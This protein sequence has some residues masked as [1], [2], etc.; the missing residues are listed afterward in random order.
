MEPNSSKKHKSYSSL[1]ATFVVSGVT[2][3]V[4]CTLVWFIHYKQLIPFVYVLVTLALPTLI[5]SLVSYRTQRQNRAA[6]VHTSSLLSKISEQG[7]FSLR[8]EPDA[9]PTAPELVQSLNHLIER[10]ESIVNE[11]KEKQ[12]QLQETLEKQK[13]AEKELKDTHKQLLETSRMAGMAEVTTGMLHNVGNTLT[14]V[15]VSATI[16]GDK[17]RQSDTKHLIKLNKLIQQHS[18]NLADFFQNNP[19]GEKIPGF[20]SNLTEAIEKEHDLYQNEITSLCKHVEHIRD[21]IS[22][23]QNYSKVIGHKEITSPIELM[24]KALF[25]NESSILRHE[26]TINKAY[27]FKDRISLESHK[28]LQILVN[29]V[30]NA[31]Q[32]TKNNNRHN[33]EIVA[34]IHAHDSERIDFQIRDNGT[35]I[36]KEN[37]NRIFQHGFTTK[38]EGHGF[39][40]HNS[41]L[42]A[43]ELGGSLKVYSDGPNQGASFILQ[44]P[45]IRSKNTPHHLS[46]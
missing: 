29:L 40:L 11:T 36:S 20:L 17:L 18:D 13:V 31:I 45:A 6:L 46:L 19:K 41:A 43:K 1:A 14:S 39:G 9:A 3:V 33:R 5:V 24:D 38:T 42:F 4:M 15:N 34:Y 32:A 22:T 35:G 12:E 37:L 10:F 23:Q 30:R 28:V 27:D 16:I 25:L 2:T 44:L 26:I 21:I 8:I 7:N